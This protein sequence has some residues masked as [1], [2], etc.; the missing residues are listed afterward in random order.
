MK[1]TEMNPGTTTSAPA[2]GVHPPPPE[3]GDHHTCRALF[4]LS[5]SAL[6]KLS[7]QGRIRSVCVR[8]EGRRRGRRFYDC[9]SIRSYLHSL[10]H[11]S[12][13]LRAL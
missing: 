12:G 9:A 7:A 8:S 1:D 11:D 3:F 5:R 4:S 6:Y 10:A 13:D 2:R